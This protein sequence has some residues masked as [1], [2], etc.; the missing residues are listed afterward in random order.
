MTGS[1]T[2]QCCRT[3]AVSRFRPLSAPNRPL[4]YGFSP[5][6]DPRCTLSVGV[7]TCE[8]QLSLVAQYRHEQFDARAAEDFTDLLISQVGGRSNGA[9]PAS[10][11]RQ[12]SAAGLGTPSCWGCSVCEFSRAMP[13]N[14]ELNL[15]L[16]VVR[17]LL[18]WAV[19]SQAILR[20][21]SCRTATREKFTDLL[22]SL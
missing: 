16:G 15:A 20:G 8:Q 12:Q 6:C 2:P 7:A 19:L 11:N 17:Q 22:I 14:W 21:L 9:D 1:S 5:P 10:W 3:W 4:N 13:S 18:E